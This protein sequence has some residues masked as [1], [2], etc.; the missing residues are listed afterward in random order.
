M[1]TND[2]KMECDSSTERD[3]KDLP[4]GWLCSL[5]LGTIKVLYLLVNVHYWG[6]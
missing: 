1:L 4:Q 3:A 6:L 5:N 2:Q